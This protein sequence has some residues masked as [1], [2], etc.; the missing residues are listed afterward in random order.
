MNLGEQAL[1]GRFPK[2]PE[3]AILSGP[4]EL[5]FCP[6]CG[7]VQL[8]HEYAADQLYGDHYGYRS[9][10]NASMTRHLKDKIGVLERAANLSTDDWVLDIGSNDGTTLGSYSVAGLN[11]IGIDPTARKF[12]EHYQPGIHVVDDFFNA[13][14]Y[15]ANTDGR[16]AKLIT[17]MAMFYDLDSPVEF[18][19]DVKASLAP[20]GLWHFEQ[21]YLPAM[22]RTNSL[23]TICHEHVSYYSFHA[24]EQIL[25]RA[26]MQVVDVSFNDINGGSFAVTATHSNAAVTGNQPVIEWVRASERAQGIETQRPLIE[27]AKRA[28]EQVAILVDLLN[29]LK[30]AGRKVIGY[31]ASTKGNVLLQYAGLGIDHIQAIG[32]INPEKYGCV[33][34]G[35]HIP[36]VSDKEA[37]DLKPD[38][39]LV[40]PWHFRSDILRREQDCL[41]RGGRFIFPLPTPEIV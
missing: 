39:F 21:S 16:R 9:G 17:S 13:A 12:R 29:R 40:L 5:L 20:D 15:L 7:L 30:R 14:R 8:G 2:S 10:L 24:I 19:R 31:G 3:E 1:T 38:Y 11:R 22:L 35:T 41:R 4:L 18:V 36:I 6:E 27:F 26:D 34:P 28:A 25:G 32:E 37:R 23:D 33:T